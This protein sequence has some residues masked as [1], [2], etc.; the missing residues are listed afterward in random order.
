[1]CGRC[2]HQSEPR[3]HHGRYRGTSGAATRDPCTVDL[4]EV[5]MYGAWYTYRALSLS[6]QRG[7]TRYD[8]RSFVQRGKERSPTYYRVGGGSIQLS[9]Q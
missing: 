6:H 7:L 8:G 2:K 3:P 5:L 1:M 4:T 9:Q